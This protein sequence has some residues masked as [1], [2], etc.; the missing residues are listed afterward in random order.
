VLAEQLDARR[1]PQI[2]AVDVEPARPLG[3]VDLARE[4][5]RGIAREP[6]RD[7][8]LGARAQQEHR[9]LIADLHAPAGDERDAAAQIGR[10][11]PLPPVELGTRRAHLVVEVV[12][13]VELGLAHVAHA[14]E[15]DARG[16]LLAARLRSRPR[17]DHLGLV[18]HD[19]RRHVGLR[20]RRAEHRLAAQRADAGLIEDRAVGVALRAEPGAGQRLAERLA[21]VAIGAR[22][23]A[24]GADQA[25]PQLLVEVGERRHVGADLLEQ[26]DR[27]P[28]LGFVHGATV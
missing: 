17:V 3:S 20:Q 28:D 13:L 25:D 27:D 4:P 14:P 21:R 5:A 26:L 6:R 24:G 12:Q 7:D 18:A 23:L 8:H 10:L 16:P 2:D 19:I 11:V 9:G 1:V 22:Q 15:L